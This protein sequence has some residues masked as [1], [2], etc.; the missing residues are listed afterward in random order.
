MKMR[1]M[2]F[3]E[4]HALWTGDSPYR[5]NR[6][7]LTPL[8]CYR[9]ARDGMPYGMIRD[10]RDP[11]EDLQQARVQGPVHPVDQPGVMD[12]GAIDEKTSSAS[13]PRWPGRTGSSRRRG[14]GS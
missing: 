8:W 6:F 1:V 13:A 2:L 10:I 11:Q 4:S 12:K 3:T 5:H 9:R 14:Q 7:P